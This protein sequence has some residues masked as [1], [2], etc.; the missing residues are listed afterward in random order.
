MVGETVGK[1]TIKEL[2][3]RGGMGTVYRALDTSLDREVAIK[4][5]NSE[6]NDPDV[7]ARFRAEAMTVA[8]LNHPGIAT[9]HELFQHN[10]MWLMVMEFVRGETFERVVERFGPMAPERAAALMSQ[11]LDA[12]GY[13]HR[14]NVVHRDLK[15][16]NLM[17]TESGAVKIMDFGIARVGGSEH[18]TQVGFTMGTPA[19]MAPEQVLGHG[20]DQRADLYAMG[21]VFYR[22]TTGQSAFKGITPFTIAQS[23]VN[24]RPIPPHQVR[25]GLPAWM[26]PLFDRALAKAPADRFQAADEFA[27]YLQRVSSSTPGQMALPTDETRMA[28]TPTAG[29]V[30]ASAA[31]RK[32]GRLA[33]IAIAGIL[34]VAL[35]TAAYFLRDRPVEPL[36][37]P[38][39]APSVA[40][41]PS[42]SASGPGSPAAA[43]ALAKK[44]AGPPAQR[45]APVRPTTAESHNAAADLGAERA[46]REGRGGRGRGGPAALFPDVLFHMGS[47]ADSHWEDAILVVAASELVVASPKDRSRLRAMPY[48]LV[49]RAACVF[50]PRPLFA[51]NLAKPAQPLVLPGPAQPQHWLTLQTPSE[52]VVLRLTQGNADRVV[53]ALQGRISIPIIRSRR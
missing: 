21:L 51:P 50:A 3:G 15:P 39:S 40:A 16:A 25:E 41:P 26:G 2:V 45:P 52:F 30:T 13:A 19:Y 8:R 47:G 37:S 27:R 23:Q 32:P 38:A 12:L 11:A 33:L 1:Y 9:V 35:A 10:G 53:E 43:T 49:L 14:M 44:P 46:A 42:V 48:R 4:V 24:D 20:V 17:L 28:P 36:T 7:A 34:A 22:M 5:M 29:T 18:L 6:L 31:G